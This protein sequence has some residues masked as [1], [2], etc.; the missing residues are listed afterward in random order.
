MAKVAPYSAQVNKSPITFT[1]PRRVSTGCVSYQQLA[2]QRNTSSNTLIQ[3]Q[4]QVKTLSPDGSVNSM[5]PTG[6]KWNGLIE[7]KDRIMM[8][9]D[10]LVER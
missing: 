6:S 3:Q 1:S 10:Q 5:E 4:Q 9:K 8:Q 7:L 2:A